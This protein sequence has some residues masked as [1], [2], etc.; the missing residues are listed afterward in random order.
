MMKAKFYTMLFLCLFVVGIVSAQNVISVSPGTDQV[1]AAMA[2][3]TAGDI[4]E[5]S[6][7]IFIETNAV[8]TINGDLTIRGADGAEVIVYGPTDAS[9]NLIHVYG[10]LWLENLILVGSDSSVY[11][12]VNYFGGVETDG[13]ELT[14]EK[15]NIYINKCLFLVFNQTHINQSASTS[16]FSDG[17]W[18]PIDTL[19]VENCLFYGADITNDRAINMDQRQVRYIEVRNSTLW[20]LG[21][22]ALQVEGGYVGTSASSPGAGSDLQYVTAIADHLTIFNTYNSSPEQG[23]GRGGDGIHFEWTNRKQSMTNTIVFRA[24]RFCFKGKR[25]E[26]TM[27]IASYCMGDS[28][29]VSGDYSPPTVYYWTMTKGPG[30]RE[31]NPFF[32]DHWNGDF[33][34]NPLLSD[35]IGGSKDGSN[36]GDLHWDSPT[37][38]WPKKAALEA[39]IAKVRD[40]GS[41]TGINNHTSTL[42]NHFALHQNYPNPFNPVTN[43]SYSLIKPSHVNLDVISITGEKVRTLVN[44]MKSVGL[45]TIT[46]DGTND[47][48]LT[49]PAG[50]YFYRARTGSTVKVKK[51]MFIK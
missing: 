25:G 33:S 18:H 3:A 27:T 12:I 19:R 28:A 11:G 46:W 15:N 45:H 29:N 39:I 17:K 31:D 4:L 8:N 10:N 42:L 7:G 51:M 30:C 43:I 16:L 35:A 21:M 40:I 14:A 1:S 34:L 5:L 48:A 32:N 9:G 22:D 13:G 49:V 24:G 44:E 41:G 37:T 36:M 47:M 6:E 20:S 2:T 50:I 38:H 26:P 23:I